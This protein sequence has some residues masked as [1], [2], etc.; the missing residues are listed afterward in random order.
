MSDKGPG[1]E[2]IARQRRVIEE[3]AR[4][5]PPASPVLER[6]GGELRRLS[7]WMLGERDEG[8]LERAAAALEALERELSVGKE[9]PPTR[10]FGALGEGAALLANARGSHPLLGSANPLAPPIELRVEGERVLGDVT[11]DVRFEGNTGWVQGGFVAAGFDIVVVQAARFSGRMGPTGSLSVRYKAPTPIGVPLRYEGRLVRAEG[12][13][14]FCEG[15]LR[16]C[17][18]DTVTAEAEVLVIAFD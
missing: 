10:F 6:L 2:V 15:D 9:G 11:F 12:R 7:G 18:D 8:E 4:G 16:R 5:E 17:D 1:Q 14:L 3:L 13:K